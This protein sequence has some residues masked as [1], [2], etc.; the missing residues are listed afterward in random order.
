MVKRM[1]SVLFAIVVFAEGG[2]WGVNKD[3]RR[4]AVRIDLVKKII[5][6]F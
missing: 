1:L 2:F 4:Y 3:G 6:F 5:D